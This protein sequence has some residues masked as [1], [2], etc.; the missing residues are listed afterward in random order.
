M[1]ESYLLFEF[2]LP[3]HALELNPKIDLAKSAKKLTEEF[4][5][6]KVLRTS[7]GHRQFINSEK[8]VSI[9]PDDL[10]MLIF[11]DEPIDNFFKMRTSPR[12]LL[13]RVC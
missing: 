5:N 1:K 13:I 3:N 6:I 8:F 12:W 2:P 10:D 7:F 11:Q 4:H 9:F